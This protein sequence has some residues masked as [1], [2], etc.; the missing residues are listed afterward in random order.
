MKAEVTMLRQNQKEIRDGSAM[1]QLRLENKQLVA[2]FNE[3][4]DER[5]KEIEFWVQERAQ[6]RDKID[7]LEIGTPQIG[8]IAP[9]GLFDAENCADLEAPTS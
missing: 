6:M 5:K 4:L 8:V 7:Q 9:G 3:Q 2:K 1:E